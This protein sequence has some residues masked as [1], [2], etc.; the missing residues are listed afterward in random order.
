MDER[1][2]QEALNEVRTRER[3]VDEVARRGSPWWYVTGLAAVFLAIS[4]SSDL[5]ERL[6][7]GWPGQV[8]DYAIPLVGLAI[9]WWLFAALNR[10]MRIRIR[11]YSG[12]TKAYQVCVLA[13][14]LFVYIGLGTVLRLYEVTWDSTISGAVAT[15]VFVGGFLAIRR[16]APGGPAAGSQ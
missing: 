10:S 8:A 15:L 14:F 4:V 7:T 11:R 9:I 1:Q 3:Q 16:A 6:G 12:K 2:A 5:D 13:A